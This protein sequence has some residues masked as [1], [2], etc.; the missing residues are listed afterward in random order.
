MMYFEA[1]KINEKNKVINQSIATIDKSM[2]TVTA[3][4]ATLSGLIGL[5]GMSCLFSGVIQ[6][7]LMGAAKSWLFAVFGG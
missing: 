1:H 3:V 6:A 7:G 4:I 5:W 2:A